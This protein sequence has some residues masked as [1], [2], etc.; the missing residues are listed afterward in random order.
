MVIYIVGT[1]IAESNIAVSSN[2]IY[3]CIYYMIPI[4]V[5]NT[6]FLQIIYILKL[7]ISLTCIHT[8]C[9]IRNA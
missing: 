3:T 8:Y 5:S 2:N 7:F 6:F 1:E 4:A 9:T